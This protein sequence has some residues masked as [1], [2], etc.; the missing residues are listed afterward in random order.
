MPA[1]GTLLRDE[2]IADVLTYVRSEW[3]NKA[4]PVSPD[5]VRQI[6]AAVAE[7]TGPWTPEELLKI[8]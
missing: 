4:P 8:P 5:K 2:Q 6:R 3:G 1:F 7:H